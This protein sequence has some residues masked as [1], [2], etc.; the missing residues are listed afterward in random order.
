[1]EDALEGLDDED[2]EEEAEEAVNKVIFEVTNGFYFILFYFIF[3]F[4][5]I[6]IINHNKRTSW[7]CFYCPTR[8]RGGT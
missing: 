2:L 4:L 3:L 7:R 5:E 8:S 6:I 1:M